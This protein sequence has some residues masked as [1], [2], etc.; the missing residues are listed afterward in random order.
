MIAIDSAPEISAEAARR[1]R[2]V[3]MKRRATALL[4]A[5]TLVFL[6][7][8]IFGGDSTWAG[9][10]QAGAEAAMIGGLV[11]ST[12][13]RWDAEETA[14]RLELLLGPDLQFIRVNG[15]VVGACA[16][17]VLHAIVQLLG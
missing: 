8:T 5:V 16:G 7:V 12:I 10:V 3:V 17:L 14:S 2:L 13:A 11:E 4:G 15:T 9:Y 1:R 6:A